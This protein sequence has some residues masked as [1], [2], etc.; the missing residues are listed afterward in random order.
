MSDTAESS[1]IVSFAHVDSGI[2]SVGLNAVAFVN[3]T[4]RKST[5]R[6]PKRRVQAQAFAC[7]HLHPLLCLTHEAPLGFE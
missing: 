3:E 6:D 5:N 1:I 4:Y 2:T 7:R